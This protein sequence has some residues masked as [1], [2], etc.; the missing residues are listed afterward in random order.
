[1]QRVKSGIIGAMLGYC[2]MQAAAD[3]EAKVE[4]ARRNLQ[5]LE[6]EYE[7]KQE[8]VQKVGHSWEEG[9]GDCAKREQSAGLDVH[10][11]RLD[12]SGLPQR[13]QCKAT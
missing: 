10:S 3:L 5:R 7:G 13:C 1:M 6:Q 12:K 8:T 4:A 9:H 2:C 11:V